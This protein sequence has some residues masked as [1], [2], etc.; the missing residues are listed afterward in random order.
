MDSQLKL[1][2]PLWNFAIQ[3][4]QNTDAQRILLG[5]QNK[6]QTR[7]NSCLSALWIARENISATG[8]GEAINASE[9]WHQEQVRPLRQLRKALDTN[10]TL[11]EH[12][13]H[14]LKAEISAEQF[15]LAYLY[16]HIMNRQDKTRSNKGINYSELADTLL[17]QVLGD[18][19]AKLEAKNIEQLILCSQASAI[20]ESSFS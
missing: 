8:L 16:Q 20:I 11:E 6:Y 12:Q 17:K 1:E 5:W 10:P 15:E 14:L 3:L 19:L 13:Q 18:D 2:T 4:W 9:T 7:V